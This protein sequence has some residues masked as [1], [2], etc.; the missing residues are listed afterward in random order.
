MA[1]P[2]SPTPFTTPPVNPT[3]GGAAPASRIPYLS[4]SGYLTYPTSMSTNDLIPSTSP[5]QSNA[6][7]QEQAAEDLL[8]RASE[9]ADR[10]CFGAIASSN[11]PGLR[12]SLIVESDE[13]PIIRGWLRLLCD[14]RPILE[15]RGVDAGLLMGS[16]TPI[17]QTLANALRI[18]RRTIYVPYS[19]PFFTSAFRNYPDV[20]VPNRLVVV[21]SYVGGFPHTKLQTAIAANDPTCT[22]SQTDGSGGLLG[23]YPGTTMEI[24]DGVN[25][26]SF[27]VQSVA[28][29]VVTPTSPFTLAHAL[30]AA[31][32]FTA[33]T[34]V[35][36]GVRLACSFLINA[37]LKTRGDSSIALEEFTEP[38]QIQKTRGDI[39]A[40]ITMAMKLLT[41]YKIRVKKPR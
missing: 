37:L 27:V 16:L 29:N 5:A 6:A 39:S 11:R 38:R 34:A 14:V 19:V 10:I 1:A 30:P 33:V 18:G 28:G 2:Y 20:V 21:W 17:G 40:D 26:E 23:I 24:V 3:F 13:V 36:T 8:I 41:P 35:P 32:D 15:V 31:P 22:L 12:A 9:W 4:L 7:G 25:T